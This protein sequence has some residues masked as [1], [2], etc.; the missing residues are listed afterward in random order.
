M[1]MPVD[2]VSDTDPLTVVM[3]LPWLM[4]ADV[5][6]SVMTDAPLPLMT[7]LP[8]LE[9]VP[10]AVKVMA[11][12]VAV[13]T[14][15]TTTCLPLPPAVSVMAPLPTV[16]T[17]TTPTA[18]AATVTVPATVVSLMAELC[19]A[20]DWLSL[21]TRMSPPTPSTVSRAEMPMSMSPLPVFRTFRL[22]TCAQGSTTPV[23]ADATRWPARIASV[24]RLSKLGLAT[25]C[26]ILPVLADRVMLAGVLKAVL[27]SSVFLM[28]MPPAPLASSLRSPCTRST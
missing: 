20:S 6:V 27:A 13:I 9:T 2:A 17:P 12:V 18:G 19:A 23:T 24:A 16:V 21:S 11:P 1:V 8:V 25:S 26:R 28:V 7:P 14:F 10:S 3:L 5:E 4:S 22:L 15:C